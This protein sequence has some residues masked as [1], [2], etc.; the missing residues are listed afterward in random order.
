M[1]RPPVRAC[2]V[3]LLALVLCVTGCTSPYYADRGAFW[4]ALGGTG[5]GALIGHASGNTGA[6]AA[7]GG[8]V[9]TGAGAAVG[10][11]LDEI[12]ARNRAQIERQ[13]GRRIQA[14]AVRVDDVIAMSQAGVDDKLIINH[15]RATGMAVPPQ[16]NDLIRLKQEGVSAEVIAAMQE[17]P[18]KVRPVLVYPDSPPPVIIHEY[19][20]PVIVH[21]PP[22]GWH[23][24]NSLY[25]HPPRPPR[26]GVSFGFSYRD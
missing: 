9:G 14:G 1:Q 3:L 12:E 24:R 18:G 4:G 21:P 13:L 22:R 7:I 20:P 15:V 8:L 23:R 5:V 26:S 19:P 16:T 2:V 11:A 25:R 10:S 6:G 17:P